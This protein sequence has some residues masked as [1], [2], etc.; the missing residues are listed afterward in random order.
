MAQ[1]MSA[2]AES[3]AIRAE[4]Q[5]RDW[6]SWLMILGFCFCIAMP[7]LVQLSGL[8]KAANENRTLAPAPVWPTQVSDVINLP[9]QT[10][11][12]LNDR[13]GLRSQLVLLNSLARYAIDVSTTSTVAIGR[14][15]YLFY[16]YEPERPPGAAYGGGLLH[17]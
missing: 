1:K 10:E 2:P 7:G 17:P 9:R 16:A 5:P 8:D 13:F 3:V 14:H 4:D 15:K 6:T 11:A 12:Y